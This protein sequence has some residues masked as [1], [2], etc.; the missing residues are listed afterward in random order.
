V[1]L[2]RDSALVQR[3]Y[4][5]CGTLSKISR[6]ACQFRMYPAIRE[7]LFLLNN[8]STS[9]DSGLSYVRFIARTMCITCDNNRIFYITCI[10]RYNTD[11]IY[12][13][14]NI[15]LKMLGWTL[16]L[17]LRKM[18][19][20]RILKSF[21]YCALRTLMNKSISAEIWFMS[22]LRSFFQYDRTVRPRKW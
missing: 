2:H 11:K 14:K 16:F 10:T 13:I 3:N 6:L 22:I 1:L 21:F 17:E 20:K 8:G 15:E 7:C 9:N 19:F 18:F 12:Q 4:W 5:K